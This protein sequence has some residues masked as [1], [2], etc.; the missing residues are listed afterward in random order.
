MRRETA[1]PMGREA[2]EWLRKLHGVAMPSDFMTDEQREALSGPVISYVDPSLIDPK[3]ARKEDMQVKQ[4]EAAEVTP[5]REPEQVLP[6]LTKEAL[7]QAIREGKREPELLAMF[8]VK[9]S[10]LYTK[11]REWKLTVPIRRTRASG[12]RITPDNARVDVEALE[13][14]TVRNMEMTLQKYD[15]EHERL[16][17]QIAD[18]TRRA[19]EIKARRN[20]LAEALKVMGKEAAS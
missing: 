3:F 12:E 6:E 1:F 7:E 14:L 13:K 17:L 18:L 15:V 9:R 20:A 16:V 2:N 8:G 10:Y 19:E 11:K 5:E 4:V